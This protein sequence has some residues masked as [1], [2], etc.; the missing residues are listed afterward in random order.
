MPTP[1]GVLGW[2]IVRYAGGSEERV[3][4]NYGENIAN[5]HL[6]FGDDN[7]SCCY[8][9]EPV[10]EGRDETG[11]PVVLYRAEWV[12]PYPEKAIAGIEFRSAGGQGEIRL[13][14]V[15]GVAVV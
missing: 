6:R 1:E 9:A 12:N 3:A 2:Y 11:R 4:I 15:T 14:G 7:A 13:A 10:W 5:W 8:W